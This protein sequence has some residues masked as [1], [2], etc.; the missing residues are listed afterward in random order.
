MLLHKASLQTAFPAEAYASSEA[1]GAMQPPESNLCYKHFRVCGVHFI[2]VVVYLRHTIGLS[3]LN[4]DIIHKFNSLKDNG[5]RKII[6][7]GDFNCP[8]EAWR[9]SGLLE[10]LG[11]NSNNRWQRQHLQDR[12]W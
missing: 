10:L 2:Y 9:A 4:M 1:N 7:A 3:G 6:I 11:L 8:P 12:Y 5:H